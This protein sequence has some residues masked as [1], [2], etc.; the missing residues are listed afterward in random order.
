MV[1]TL[2]CTYSTVS[3][4]ELLTTVVPDYRID[5]PVDCRFWQRGANDTYR[6]RCARA[7]YFLRLYR[8]GAYP[9]EANEFEAEALDY[10]HGRGVPVAHPVE[11]RSGGFLTEIAAP[12][13][14]R[15]VLLT[16]AAEGS[17]PDYDSLDTC[18]LVGESVARMHS[19]FDGFRTTRRRTRLDLQGLLESPLVVIRRFLAEHPDR[20]ELIETVARDVRAAIRAVPEA[21]LDTGVVHGDLHGGN[22]HVHEGTVR[23]FDFE[24]CAFG[25]RSYDLGT[26]KW[27]NALGTDERAVRRWQ[28]FL[29]G[30]ETA[31]PIA[32]PGRSLVDA[33]VLVRELSELAYGIRHVRDFGYGDI[34]ASDPDFVCGRIEAMREKLDA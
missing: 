6:V 5:D 22:V 11:R 34:M 10:L 31:R 21:S 15:F 26:W 3:A 24:E 33:F 12:E 29:E 20:L 16:T 4:D 17:E 28:A 14:S 13:G 8:H 30:Y 2:R 9:R 1:A 27:G 18:R 25:Y 7:E 32:E 23:H 19:G